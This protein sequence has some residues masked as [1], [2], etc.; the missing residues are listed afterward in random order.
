MITPQIRRAEPEDY[1]GICAIYAQPAAQ[2]NTMQLPWPSLAQWKE[3]LSAHNANAYVWIAVHDDEI[4]GHAGLWLA[5]ES[6][7]R[8]HVA[9]LGVTVHD[10]WQGQGVG[11]AL[12]NTLLNMADQWLNLHRLELTVYED[13]APA[14]ALYQKLG[15]VIEGAHRD[16]AFRA[17]QFVNACA[18]GRVRNSNS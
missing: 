3:R 15:F 16:Y 4:I 6:P 10:Q 18:M 2:H 9:S 14:I 17:G 13:N 5:T 1:A 12:M 11:T 7:R 8:R